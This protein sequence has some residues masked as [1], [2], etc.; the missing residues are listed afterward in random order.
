MEC[1]CHPSPTSTASSGLSTSYPLDL[2]TVWT[3]ITLVLCVLDVAFVSPC[4]DSNLENRAVMAS[5]FPLRHALTLTLDRRPVRAV[6]H[7]GFSLGGGVALVFQV[8]STSQSTRCPCLSLFTTN[9]LRPYIKLACLALRKRLSH[10]N[11]KP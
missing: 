6:T 7:G 2:E 5:H 3:R 11:P 9:L 4:F 10:T 8:R 1:V